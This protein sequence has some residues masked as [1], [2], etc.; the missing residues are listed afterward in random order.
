MTGEENDRKANP[1]SRQENFGSRQ[2]DAGRTASGE[3]PLVY[4]ELRRVEI[5]AVKPGEFRILSAAVLSCGLCE[6]VIS[7]MGGPGSG[8]ICDRCAGLLASGRL[9]G[10]VRYD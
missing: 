1:V 2:D 8:V 10:A 3:Q 6:T 5:P 9:R 4:H 7:G